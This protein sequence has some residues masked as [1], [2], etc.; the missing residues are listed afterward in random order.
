MHYKRGFYLN[1]PQGSHVFVGL[2]LPSWD[3]TFH[4]HTIGA[5]L[6]VEGSVV[7]SASDSVLMISGNEEP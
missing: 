7:F 6:T 2:V 1:V 5:S 3:R 4:G